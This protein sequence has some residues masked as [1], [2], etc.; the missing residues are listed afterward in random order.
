MGR[1]GLL[2]TNLPGRGEDEQVVTQ[3]IE[4]CAGDTRKNAGGGG[5][6]YGRTFQGVG[7]T[8]RL[9]RNHR[10]SLCLGPYG[11]HRSILCQSG[12]AARPGMNRSDDSRSRRREAGRREWGTRSGC[13]SMC[14]Q[15]CT[16]CTADS[17]LSPMSRSRSSSPWSCRNGSRRA[18]PGY[19][20]TGMKLAEHVIIATPAELEKILHRPWR[21]THGAPPSKSQ[22][23][24]WPLS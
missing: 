6:Y 23:T 21:M 22:I 17:I 5:A 19:A 2:W 12:R 8:R 9:C 13:S 18:R 20:G 4:S 3:A 10:P 16:P 1:R 14:H 15:T 24:V 11:K 7:R